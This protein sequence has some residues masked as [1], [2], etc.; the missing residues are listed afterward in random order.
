MGSEEVELRGVSESGLAN[1]ERGRRYAQARSRKRSLLMSRTRSMA[2]WTSTTA[3][4]TRGAAN[5]EL[6]AGGD[7]AE[8]PFQSAF[9]N[10]Q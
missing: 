10:L 7:D 8:G 1:A 3:R 9:Y 5:G 6:G 4:E 2:R